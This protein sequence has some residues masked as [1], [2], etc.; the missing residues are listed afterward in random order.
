VVDLAALQDEAERA[1]RRCAVG[2]L[3]R[4]G[5][6]RVFVHRRGPERRVL[7]GCWDIPGGHVEAG[8]SVLAAGVREAAEELGVTVREPDLVGVTTL[9]RT[10]E[11]GE[12]LGT[13]ED[14][15]CDYFFIATAWQGEPKIME[16]E[17]AADL[18]W[19]ALDRLPDPVVP[20]ELRVLEAVRDE[21]AGRSRVPAIMTHGW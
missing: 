4:D 16:P 9:H 5:D 8:E 14:E 21:R 2:A 6:G 15:R 19:F 10:A 12:R 7:P 20:H 3:I 18:S 1:G 13:V 17:K 11:P